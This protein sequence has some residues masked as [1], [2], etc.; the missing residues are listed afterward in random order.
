MDNKIREFALREAEQN[1]ELVWNRAW[2]AGYNRARE[3]YANLRDGEA[4]ME[5]ST[6]EQRE[7]YGND[8][9]GW[10]SRCSKPFNGSWAGLVNFCPWCG[11][12][13]R[14]GGEEAGND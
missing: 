11:R 14:W 7:E 3:E 4:I 5:L 8:L 6:K 2:E 1:A 10:C 13:V 12:P 9:V